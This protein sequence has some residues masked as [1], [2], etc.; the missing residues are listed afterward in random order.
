METIRHHG[1]A[2]MLNGVRHGDPKRAISAA[3]YEDSQYRRESLA[4]CPPTQTRR[5][6]ATSGW[7]DAV[8]IRAGPAGAHVILTTN[9]RT[10]LLA[11]RNL[12]E[13]TPRLALSRHGFGSS[14]L[15]CI[16]R[17]QV[18]TSKAPRQ[19]APAGRY[20]GQHR[21]YRRRYR[22]GR[23]VAAAYRSQPDRISTAPVTG[24][25]TAIH[26]APELETI[27][28]YQ[29]RCA[30]AASELPRMNRIGLRSWPA[31]NAVSAI[32]RR[33]RR[34][35]CPARTSRPRSPLRPYSRHLH[36]KGCHDDIGAV[37]GCAIG[38]GGDARRRD[39]SYRR[40]RMMHFAAKRGAGRRH[41]RAPPGLARRASAQYASGEVTARCD[42]YF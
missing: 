38:L 17:Q 33:R 40:S 35:C 19:Q 42:Q 4:G 13:N 8:K 16:S 14:S 24:Q 25:L 27:T 12:R 6:R 20:S 18:R 3:M 28:H 21:V 5:Q 30:G 7:S 36:G 1:Q 9:C 39:R 37:I 10:S 41:I 22:R 11:S 26:C 31:R 29:H 2:E 15:A 34:R 23:A 32:F